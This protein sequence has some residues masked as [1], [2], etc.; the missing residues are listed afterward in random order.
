[1]MN[2]SHFKTWIALLSITLFSFFISDRSAPHTALIFLVMLAVIKVILLTTQY[3]ELK[4]A[5]VAWLSVVI[6]ILSAY[7]IGTFA[8]NW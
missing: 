8:F 7:G 5:H 1:M 4:K 2:N 3:M 6:I